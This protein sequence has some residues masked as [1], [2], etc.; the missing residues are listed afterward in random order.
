M[1][2][3]D[4]GIL[5]RKM[6]SNCLPAY[7]RAMQTNNITQADAEVDSLIGRFAITAGDLPSF[8]AQARNWQEY[9]ISKLKFRVERSGVGGNNHVSLK[10]VEDADGRLVDDNAITTDRVLSSV[11]GETMLNDTKT[12]QIVKIRRPKI[13]TGI[14]DVTGA[15][16]GARRS[17][18]WIS[19]ANANVR[20]YGLVTMS[21]DY[22]NDSGAQIEPVSRDNA[23]TLVEGPLK[24]T[25]TAHV[26][27]RG[28]DPGRA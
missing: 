28:A 23:G 9:R 12:Y 8:T 4:S 19:T 14:V 16:V 21:H 24:V 27:F 11:S 18:V 1:F 5:V 3:G 20:Y 10:W 25:V 13:S 17:N 2:S 6:A 26:Q 22:Y 15:T 7:N